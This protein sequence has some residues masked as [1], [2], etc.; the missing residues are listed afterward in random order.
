MQQ[1]I[2]N[3]EVLSI[4]VNTLEAKVRKETIVLMANTESEAL[5]AARKEFHKADDLVKESL[6]EAEVDLAPNMAY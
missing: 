3:F 4:N 6:E 5:E 1:F 2:I